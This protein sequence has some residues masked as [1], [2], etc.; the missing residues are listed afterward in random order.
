MVSGFVEFNLEALVRLFKNQLAFGL[1]QAVAPDPVRTFSVVQRY[2][3]K[4]FIIV[5][6]YETVVCV[7][8]AVRQDAA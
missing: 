5:G 1:A 7:L 4:M 8:D 3:E 6:P 2:V